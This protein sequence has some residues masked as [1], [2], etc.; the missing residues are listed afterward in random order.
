[1]FEETQQVFI[2]NDKKTLYAMSELILGGIYSQMASE[3]SSAFKKAE[4]HFNKAIEVSR[5]IG[6]KWTLGRAYL[7]MGLL[8]KGMEKTDQAREFLSKSIDIFE[9]L[10]TEFFLKQAKEALASIE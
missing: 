10:D 7:S 2:K 6:A 5:E 9:E 3:T 8:Q 1:M 4:E